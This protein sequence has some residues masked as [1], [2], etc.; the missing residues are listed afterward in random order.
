MKI[1]YIISMIKYMPT[2]SWVKKKTK[3]TF[4]FEPKKEH[5]F[6]F[7]FLYARQCANIRFFFFFFFFFCFCLYNIYII[8]KFPWQRM[9]CE[10]VLSS[11]AAT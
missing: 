7:F 5:F 9:F 11:I 2:Y 1:T 6:F 3:K 10:W 8:I 4:K